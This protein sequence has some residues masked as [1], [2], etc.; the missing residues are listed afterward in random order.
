LKILKNIFLSNVFLVVLVLIIISSFFLCNREK[1]SKIDISRNEFV[2]IIK[3]INKGFDKVS[4]IIENNEKILCN[5]YTE[6]E[7]DIKLGDKVLVQGEFKKPSNNTIPNTFNYKKYLE[8]KN[9]FYTMTISEIKKI[10]DT[11]NIFY[12]IKNFLIKRIE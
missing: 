2:G 10:S 6:E 3:N 7:I 9:I 11:S 5:Y 4:F 8:S 1:V 12:M